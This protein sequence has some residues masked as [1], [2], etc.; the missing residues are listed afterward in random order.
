MDDAKTVRADALCPGVHPRRVRFEIGRG[1][2]DGF[3][4]RAEGQ[5]QAEKRNMEIKILR[6]GVGA[7]QFHAG[8]GVTEQAQQIVGRRENDMSAARLGQK[9]VAEKHHHIAKPLL[10]P[11]EEALAVEVFFSRPAGARQIA[12]RGEA[13]LVTQFQ[14]R[15][16]FFQP[17]QQQQGDG[18]VQMGGNECG[19]ARGG[20]GKSRQ[21][22]VVA[23][24]CQQRGAA[25]IPG[26]GPIG[27]CRQRLVETFQRF[28]RLA[29]LTQKL[30]AIARQNCVAGA[31]LEGAGIIGQ[32]VL[33]AVARGQQPGAV[34]QGLDIIGIGGKREVISR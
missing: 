24:Q 11:D 13:K 2:G 15:P 3:E 14:Q 12:H 10:P 1:G 31:K 25:I 21:G 30:T 8:A 34:A 32:R 6:R 7:D 29:N 18:L 33:G 22:V 27:F 5:R 17:A 20:A 26:F 4:P 23:P 19:I 16:A 28:L 9:R